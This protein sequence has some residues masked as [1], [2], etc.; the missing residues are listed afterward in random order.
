MCAGGTYIRL[1]IEIEDFVRPV[2]SSD[3]SNDFF[4]D[5]GHRQS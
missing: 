2:I 4:Q 3:S 1:C 5:F